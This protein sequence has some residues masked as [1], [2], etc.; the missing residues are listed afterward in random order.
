MKHVTSGRSTATAMRRGLL[1][2]FALTAA[3]GAAVAALTMPATP[4]ATAATDPCAASE[5]AK[6]I[7][8]VANNT[9]SYLDSHP[10]TNAA[11]T[12]ASQSQGGPAALGSV[13]T[14]FDANPQA[15]KEM[16]ALQAPLTNLSGRCKLPLT[17]PQV[18]GLMQA[19]HS[20][21]GALPGGTL[22]GGLPGS[23]PSAQAVGVPVAQAPPGTAPVS[24]AR[25]GVGPL[26]GPM[27][28]GTR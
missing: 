16:Q 1:G 27:T 14:Y 6:T 3:G 20:Q 9:G 15:A 23:L 7:G 24:A 8:T 12:T 19:A 11:L 17:I 4:S 21:G 25:Q 5:V 18:L 10:E 22:Q 13:K 28:A 2:A 26:P